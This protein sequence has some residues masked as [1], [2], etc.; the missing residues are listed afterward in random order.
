MNQIPHNIDNNTLRQ[1]FLSPNFKNAV[2]VPI[3]EEN[4]LPS[5]ELPDIY[6]NTTYEKPD[7]FV[8][9]VKKVDMMGMI[10]PWFE[11]PLL[12][13]A[14][15][16]ALIKGVDKFTEACGGEYEKS[17]LGK[18]TR[19]GDNI[20]NALF[21]NKF[22]QKTGAGVKNVFGKIN[23]LL[24]KSSLIR[25]MRTT[26]AR[27]EKSMPKHEMLSQEV[28]FIQ[29]FNDIVNTLKLNPAAGK[30]KPLGDIA[31]T[32]IGL[33]KL[34]KEFLT[35]T[36]GKEYG[37]VAEEKLVNSVLLKR[38]NY[39]ADDITRIIESGNATSQVKDA[40][41]KK[42]GLTID[43]LAKIAAKPEECVNQVKEAVS[44]AGK[45]VRIGAGHYKWLG[46]FQP[47]ER[48]ISCDQ[49]SNKFKSVMEGAKTSTGRFLSKLIHK[50]HRGFTFGGG[51]G[52]MLLFIAPALVMAMKST[53]KAEK[54]EKVGTA[55]NGAL[56]SIT[57]VFTF[58]LSIAA[59]YA[60]GGM[61]FAGMSKE[62]VKRFMEKTDAFNKLVDTGKLM[63]KAKYDKAYKYLMKQRKALTRVKSQNLFGR[64][65]RKI[66]NFFYCDL[67]TVRSYKSGN[68]LMDKVRQIPNFFKHLG[69]EPIRFILC[70]FVIESFFRKLIEKGIKGVFG[71]HYDHYKEEEIIAS[72]KQQKKFTK[73]ELEK[74][75][76]EAQAVKVLG[77]EAFNQVPVNGEMPQQ[78]NQQ[79]YYDEQYMSEENQAQKSKTVENIQ[80]ENI[81]QEK[82]I[83]E[84]T[85]TQAQV[86]EPVQASY[87][88]KAVSQ[89][90]A[91]T[92]VPK[93]SIPLVAKEPVQHV[94]AE[95]KPLTAEDLYVKEVVEPKYVPSQSQ[96]LVADKPKVKRDNYTYIPS[97]E[98]LFANTKKENYEVNKY[99]PA[100]TA[101]K[102]TK[103]FDNSGLANALR[104]ADLAEQRA[105]EVLNGKFAGM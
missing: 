38:L 35:R 69:L 18:V 53:K 68:I 86:Q 79:Q 27:P 29:E 52:S 65:M 88:Q 31:L 24:N 100:Q 90:F 67:N 57:W 96:N 19:F 72:K 42:L 64:M 70:A 23:N 21:K 95:S 20:E 15:S 60:L 10:Y 80:Q 62:N 48:T 3:S 25:A 2:S 8:D 12:M 55:V 93:E 71:N 87:P 32:E 4:I 94:K 77:P 46:P 44:R 43:D 37:K 103:T 36:F 58:P 1:R 99:I 6:Q 9:K 33:D 49:I 47:L 13:G 101:A 91:V 102:I 76:Y 61:R 51:K 81:A 92:S 5:I 11:N 39:S 22:M 97:S 28:R 105:I 26:P 98:N 82:M 74:R 104:R 34:E 85:P 45:S 75:L 50:I 30:G 16:Y 40:I 56:E 14:T 73:E 17:L 66:T 7:T 84:P 63:D 41:L 89:D 83:Q 78:F 54:G 59:T